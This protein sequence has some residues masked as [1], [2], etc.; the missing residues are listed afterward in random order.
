VISRDDRQPYELDKQSVRRAFERAAAGYDAAAVVQREVGRRMLER[1]ELMRIRPERILDVGAGTGQGSIALARRYRGARVVALDLAHA[2]LREVRRRTPWLSKVRCVCADMERLPFA[3]A[4]FD[5]VHS[6]ATLQWATDLDGALGE[7]HRVLR[8]GGLLLFSTF[9]PDTLRELREAWAQVDGHT[10]VHAF[11]DM[12][13]IGDALLRQ[14]LADPVMDVER[15]TVT[16][17]DAYRLMHD[18]K[19]IGAHNAAQGRPRGLTGRRRLQA[20]LEAYE[21]FRRDGVLPASYEIVYGHAW[22]AHGAAPRAAPG[23]P[24]AVSLERLRRRE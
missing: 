1:L 21:S 20:M 2:M 17:P 4:S 14:G 18:L 13:D 23:A 6:N 7:L 3:D 22:G 15:L 10:H 5:M 19:G 8:P 24:V 9:G 12:H 11:L 16:Y